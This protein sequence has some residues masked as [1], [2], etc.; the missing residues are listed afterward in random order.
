MKGVFLKRPRIE[1]FRGRQGRFEGALVF[2]QR[3]GRKVVRGLTPNPDV[4][5]GV[6]V[7]A[8]GRPVCLALD[9]PLDAPALVRSVRMFLAGYEG[10]VGGGAPVR[11]R[12][13]VTDPSTVDLLLRAVE[14]L[15][16]RLARWPVHPATQRRA[17]SA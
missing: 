9:E 14:M 4:M 6:G 16:P 1:V 13:P 15:P 5:I 7:D 10:M 12:S 3:E 17:L 2:L 8:E 11:R